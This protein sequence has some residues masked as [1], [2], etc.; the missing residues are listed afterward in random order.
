MPVDSARV[1]S[2]QKNSILP[3]V[4]LSVD[5]ESAKQDTVPVHLPSYDGLS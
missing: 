1:V 5:R 3:L 2:R 4:M